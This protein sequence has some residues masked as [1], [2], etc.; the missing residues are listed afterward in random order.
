[1]DRN[2]IFHRLRRGAM[3]ASVLLWPLLVHSPA[4]ASCAE[5]T[6]AEQRAQADVVFDGRA[7]PGPGVDGRLSTP[8]R[9][10]VHAYLEGDGPDLVEV[11]TA[12]RDE[13]GGV[14]SHL[15]TG[16]DPRAG[17]TWRIYAQQ[18]AGGGPLETSVC[19]GSTRLAA[20][21]GTDADTVPGAAQPGLD[22]SSG[23]GAAPA[24]LLLTAVAL[25]VSV[26]ALAGRR[27]QRT[28]PA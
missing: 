25:T 19:A 1:M 18:P 12:S 9:F 24:V 23:G 21:P 17:E 26:V 27:W 6:E 10:E 13:G 4:Y 8:A 11:V 28:R 20:A 14:V 22:G 7:L 16:I 15:S 3:T 2:A 5:M